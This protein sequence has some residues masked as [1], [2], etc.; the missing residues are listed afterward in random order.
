M[1]FDEILSDGDR[2]IEAGHCFF[3]P[4]QRG[5][6]VAAVGVRFR[7]IRLDR[8]C[9]IVTLQ[10]LIV[11]PRCFQRC[12][13]LQPGFEGIRLGRHQ[14]AIDQDRLRLT[15]EHAEK[16]RQSKISVDEVTPTGD[17]PVEALHGLIGIAAVS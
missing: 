5:E 13:M 8:N 17:G 7:N 15:A 16:I 6:H 1:N 9:A 2:F 4:T 11:A 3:M 14:T 10:C 12:S